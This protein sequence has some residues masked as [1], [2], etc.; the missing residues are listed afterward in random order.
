MNFRVFTWSA[1]IYKSCIFGGLH[2]DGNSS[3]W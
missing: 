1:C 2:I 3:V